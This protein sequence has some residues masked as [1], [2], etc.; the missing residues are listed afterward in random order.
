MT[1]TRNR[2]NSKGVIL[3]AA[4]LDAELQR[5]HRDLHS[6]FGISQSGPAAC[7]AWSDSKAFLTNDLSIESCMPL[8]RR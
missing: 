4:R 6:L 3:G 8:R 2:F 1:T 7:Y 5:A